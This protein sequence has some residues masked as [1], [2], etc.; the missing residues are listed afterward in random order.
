MSSLT[1][2]ATIYFDPEIHKTLKM[3]S[4]EISK[5]VSELIDEIIRRELL[6]SAEDLSVFDERISEP[7]V[8]YESMVKKLKRDGKI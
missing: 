3:K 2:R 7:T 4:V 8:S 6:E 1:K 5:S